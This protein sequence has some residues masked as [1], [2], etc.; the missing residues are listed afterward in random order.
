MTIN[1]TLL[2]RAESKCELCLSD[3]KLEPFL[4][5]PKTT[6]ETENC[7]LVCSKCLGQLNHTENMDVNHWRILNDT[8][9]NPT[10]A[11]QVVVWRIL[12]QL[13]AEGWPRDLLDNLYL[14]EDTENLA[15]SLTNSDSTDHKIIHLDSNGVQLETGDSITIIKDL[16]VKG[17]NFTA[18]RGTV[19]K[20]IYLV[21]DNADH[22]EGKV[23]EQSIVILTKFV[24]KN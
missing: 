4:V 6:D 7:I 10:P 8:M 21:K 15:K 5:P 12:D 1:K 3:T 13:S 16:V 24:K 9:W 19:V 23:N 14:D 2:E 20:S 17:A 18:K 11:V 22:I